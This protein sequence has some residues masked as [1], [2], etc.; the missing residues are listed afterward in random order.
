LKGWETN[1]KVKKLPEIYRKAL[2]WFY[3]DRTAPY[4]AQRDMGMSLS[5][6][7]ETVIMARYKVAALSSNNRNDSL[8][9][10]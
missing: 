10:A 9:Y 6:L 7:N 3:I 8:K 4:K 5:G 1:E 2:K